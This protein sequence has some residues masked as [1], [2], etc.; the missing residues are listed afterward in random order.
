MPSATANAT[1]SSQNCPKLPKSAQKQ[2]FGIPPE[3]EILVFLKN[4]TFYM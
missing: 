3:I 4:K 2:N 1:K